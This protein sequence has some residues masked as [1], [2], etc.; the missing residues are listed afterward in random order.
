MVVWWV[1]WSWNY[2]FFLAFVLFKVCLFYS[3]IVRTAGC[4]FVIF[5]FLFEHFVYFFKG[6]F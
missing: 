5:V 3:L 1:R 4:M 6:K 2:F